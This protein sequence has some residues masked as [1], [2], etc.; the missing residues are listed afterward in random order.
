MAEAKS[1]H[2]Y[3]CPRRYAACWV[4][5]C[6]MSSFFTSVCLH[7]FPLH[8]FLF[9]HHFFSLSLSPLFFYTLLIYSP[10]FFFL[11]FILFALCFLSLSFLPSL[12][13]S[14]S[15]FIPFFNPYFSDSPPFFL[16]SFIFFPPSLC[17]LGVFAFFQS[18]LFHLPG[19]VPISSLWPYLRYR[20]CW[21]CVCVCE[22]LAG[23]RWMM[24]GCESHWT[25]NI[26]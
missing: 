14:L 3:G 13:L 24:C 20:I 1:A 5:V 8:V 4:F 10:F 26:P 11:A 25:V 2:A 19:C 22:I 16:S 17:L 12:F 23:W 7:F 6:V 9:I 15:D 18:T 21:M